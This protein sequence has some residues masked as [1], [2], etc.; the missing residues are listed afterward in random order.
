MVLQAEDPPC[1]VRAMLPM[2]LGLG[3]VANNDRMFKLIS[4]LLAEMLIHLLNTSGRTAFVL[5]LVWANH[6]MLC[7]DCLK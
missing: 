1:Y 4:C 2:G 7:S 5:M 6:Q 3:L